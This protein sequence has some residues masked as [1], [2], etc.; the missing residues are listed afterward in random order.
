MNELYL[1]AVK[2]IK[3]AILKSQNRAAEYAN[4]E[5]LSLYYSI[6]AFVS[7]NSR[8]GKW[9]SGALEE[10]SARLHEELPGL[11]GFRKAI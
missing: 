5:M 10:I 11:R 6:G 3:T 2:I 4:R 8:D 9:G 7:Q 1:A